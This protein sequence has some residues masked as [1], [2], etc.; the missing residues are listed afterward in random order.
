MEHTGHQ[1]VFG[2]DDLC[3]LLKI[4]VCQAFQNRKQNHVSQIY[5]TPNFSYDS[6]S[7][8]RINL[9]MYIFAYVKFIYYIYISLATFLT[10]T[11]IYAYKETPNLSATPMAFIRGMRNIQCLANHNRSFLVEC[12]SVF[13]QLSI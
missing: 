2:S 3:S 4:S 6:Y 7:Y 5:F 12:Q 11:Y 8:R 13:Q 10:Y 1:L 9:H